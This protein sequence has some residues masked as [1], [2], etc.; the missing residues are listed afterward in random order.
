M[1]SAMGVANAVFQRDGEVTVGVTYMTGTL[2][3]FGQ[4]LLAAL[5]GGPRFA[6]MPYFLLWLGLVGGAMAGAAVFPALGL[7]ALWIA[8][9]FAVFLLAMAISLGPLPKT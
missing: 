8:A 3:K 6:W 4:Y 9:A 1:A 2:V 5:C 7:Q